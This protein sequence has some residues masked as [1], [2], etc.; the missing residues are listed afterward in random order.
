M[1]SFLA[2]FEHNRERP[3]YRYGG[4]IESLRLN[5]YY[6]MPKGHEHDPFFRLVLVLWSFALYFSGKKRS[7][8]HPKTAQRSF[9]LITIFSFFLKQK[10]ARKA[11]GHMHTDA[12]ISGRAHALWASHNTP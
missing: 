2:F 6:G 12:S 4:H 3:I 8:L 7:L 9:F 1:S 5:E 11:R 10:L